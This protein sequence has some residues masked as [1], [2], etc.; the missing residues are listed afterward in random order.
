MAEKWLNELK[1]LVRSKDDLIPKFVLL[2][3]KHLRQNNCDYRLGVM[4]LSDYFFQRSHKFRLG[5]VENIEVRSIEKILYF[6]RR[7]LNM[8]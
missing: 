6:F 8:L 3:L 1:N 4:I 5:M 2:I 7:L